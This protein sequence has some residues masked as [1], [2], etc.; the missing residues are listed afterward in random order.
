MTSEWRF[1]PAGEGA[2][3]VGFFIDFQFKSRTLQML[4]GLLFEEA[5]K[6][7][8]SAFETRAKMLY[9]PQVGNAAS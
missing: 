4:I 6:R 5:V 8:V 2:T 7:I 9:R 1:E 3:N